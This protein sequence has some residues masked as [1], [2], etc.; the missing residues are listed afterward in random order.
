MTPFE[1][2]REQPSPTPDSTVTRLP[3]DPDATLSRNPDPS[4]GT[5]SFQAGAS[6]EPKRGTLP[7]QAI[8]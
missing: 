1:P 7:G 3:I 8:S 4:S 5:I 2:T 6:I